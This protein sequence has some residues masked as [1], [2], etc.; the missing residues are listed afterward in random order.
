M[1]GSLS[2]IVDT[3]AKG[4]DKIEFKDCNYFLES[5]SVGGKLMK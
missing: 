3:L 1:T 5:E 4:I 2:N